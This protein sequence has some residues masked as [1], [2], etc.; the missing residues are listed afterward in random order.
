MWNEEWE[1]GR[2]RQCTASVQIL[3]SRCTFTESA[4]SLTA[5]RVCLTDCGRERAVWH[6]PPGAPLQKTMISPHRIYHI[7]EVPEVS[8]Y[9]GTVDKYLRTY[10]GS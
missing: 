4:C 2:E 6:R 5:K 3:S 10:L 7:P 9:L 8:A 1:D